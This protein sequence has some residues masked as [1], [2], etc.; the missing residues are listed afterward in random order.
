LRYFTVVYILVEVQVLRILAFVVLPSTIQ[1]Y[2]DRPRNRTDES[3]DTHK[4]IYNCTTVRWRDVVE[5]NKA[6]PHSADKLVSPDLIT[7]I[8]DSINY[9][10]YASVMNL[11]LLVN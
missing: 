7:K 1:G 4:S 5:L 3:K 10:V 2:K 6:N 11:F 8:N 9:V